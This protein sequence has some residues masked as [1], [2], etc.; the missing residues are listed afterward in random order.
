MF[1]DD[2]NLIKGDLRDFDTCIKI[3]RQQE[4]VFHVAGIKGSPQ[5][6]LKQPNSFFFNTLLFNLNVIEASRRSGVENFLYTSSVG[7]YAPAS[8]FHE[9]DVWSSFPSDNDRYAGWAKRMGELQLEAAKIQH[10]WLNTHIVR[11]AN[12]FGPWDNFDPENAMVIPSLIC[13]AFSSNDVLKVWGDGSAIRD[14]IFSLDV[15]KAMLHVV[16][17]NINVPVNV[18]SGTG[19][20]IKMLAESI[21]KHFP[22]L[23]LEWDSTK[24]TGDKIRVLDTS[25]IVESGFRPATNLDDGISETIE[26]YRNNREF[27]GRYNAFKETL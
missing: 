20:S 19:I 8:I 3:F 10:G 17:N 22:R 25:K 16:E 7:V 27:S 9:E 6:A 4:I 2:F 24:P 18:G 26:W 12:I 15:A 23:K 14:F 21:V 13:K 1:V 5:V 11:P